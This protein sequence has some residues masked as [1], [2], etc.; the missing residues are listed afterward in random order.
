MLET[1]REYAGEALT[2]RTSEAEELAQRH[3]HYFLELAETAEPELWAQHTDHGSRD[4][5]PRKRTSELRSVTPSVARKRRL[6]SGLRVPSIRSGR[7]ARGTAK[8][9]RGSNGRSPWVGA[10]PVRYRAKALVA[11]GRATS[12]QSDWPTAIPVLEEAIELSRELDDVQGV[13]R[14]LG[15]IGHARL[16]TGDSEGA[17][18]ALDEGV[19]LARSTGDRVSIARALYNAAWA[20]IE[21]RDFD[22]ARE[23]FEEA[24]RIARAE[25]MKP[26][27]ALGLMRLGY[28]EALAGDFE[29]AASRLDESVVLFDELGRD[30]VDAGRSPLPRSSRA[31]PRE[32]R[33]GG[34]RF[35]G[36]A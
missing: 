26:N 4:S 13:G 18:A 20:A 36:Q 15:F 21:Q 3:L 5:I 8:R 35:S 23:M 24:N 31:S 22:R 16:Y 27:L 28:T 2:K 17:A 10:V 7:S 19:Q 30:D 1:I 32:D 9:A 11:A 6:P 12:W 33:R 25:G 34:V 29:R 14:C